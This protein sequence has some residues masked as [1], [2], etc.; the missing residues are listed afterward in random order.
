M[1]QCCGISKT[2]FGKERFLSFDLPD[3]HLKRKTKTLY[4]KRNFL[5]KFI[6]YFDDITNNRTRDK[7]N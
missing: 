5:I 7:T 4:H 6:R 1:Q 3:C 2:R